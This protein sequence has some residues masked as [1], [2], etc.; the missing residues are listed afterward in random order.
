M[1]RQPVS[2][3]IRLSVRPLTAAVAALLGVQY[4]GLAM[5]QEG[6]G[7]PRQ[8]PL[9]EL[10]V[11]ASRRETTIQEIPFNIAAVS[12]VE[13]ERQ[14]IT[15]LREFA[16]TVP[17]LSVA[18]QGPRAAEL[19]TVR[20]LNVASL[21]ASEFL[22]N[23]GGET[24]A[25]YL[26]QVPLYI[27]FKMKDLERIEVLLGPQGTLYGEGTLAGAVR[28]MPVRPDT[29]RFSFDVHG[30]FYGLD[31]SSGTGLDTDAVW[32]V[33]LSDTLAFRAAVSYLDDPGFID[34][35]YVL[36]E[37]GVSN[38]QPDFSDPADVAANLIRVEDA[39]TEQTL[40]S[41]LALLWEISDTVEA[42]LNYYY[43]DQDVGGRTVNHRASFGTDIY[44]SGARF[45]EPNVR[46]NQLV[47]LEVVADLGFAELTSA[48]GVSSFEERG[49]R[50]QTDLLLDFEYGYEDFP[51][52]AAFT[53][54]LVDED[55]VNQEFRLVSTGEGPW[56]WIGGL[57]YN[58]YE[59]SSSSE[60]F[61][62]GFPEFID[63]I[64]PDNLE[65]RQVDVETLTET[66]LFGEVS[67]QF[68]ERLQLT[69]GA[70][71]FQ[72]D[73]DNATAVEIPLIAFEQAR[74][75]SGGDDG[76]LGKLNASYRFNE[77]MM[78]YVTLSEGYRSGGVNALP[79]CEIPLPPGQN[80]CALPQEKL[81]DPDTTLN[82]ELGLHSVWN[83]GRL[84]LNGAL[85]QID[86]TDIQT[87]TFSEN[88]SIPITINGS[89]ARSRGLEL[90]V[91]AP[92]VGPLS[93]AGSYA[94][95]H[96]EMTE[97][98]PGLVDGADAEAGDRLPGTP[99]HQGS[100]SA[101]YFRTLRNGY[102]LTVDYGMSFTSDVLTKIGQ[103]NDGETLGGFT[104]HNASIGLHRDQWSA[105]LFADNLTN[106]F[107]E[108]AVRLDPSFIRSVGG[109]DLRRYYRHVI[110]PRSIG[111][112]LRY[113]FGE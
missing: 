69:V 1:I 21:N 47:S 93:L 35:P 62:P 66:A 110:R 99:E 41:R 95:T 112:E 103:R 76:V 83:D 29:Q 57:F 51:S 26:G 2:K 31:Q 27:D 55:R 43:Q 15:S 64:Q 61:V 80:V 86:W 90:S 25:T 63:V 79:D 14:R 52:F 36:R 56:S 106:K 37:P 59:V 34:Y 104:V 40:S 32:N 68:T 58:D 105:V 74:S 100:F 96:A 38:P 18:D 73:N 94:Y 4:A 65:Y 67:Y 39:D 11:T 102:D 84:V 71:W 92:R 60:E 87:T 113:R 30:S 53:R 88:G 49:Q 22:A 17:G 28:Y 109:F 46:T 7:G 77:D 13:L 70:R 89:Q 101:S 19:M 107:A 111:V 42:T 98:A 3:P 108:T 5:A 85:F 12:G 50:D 48:T 91:Q 24:V 81:Y 10:I 16:R 33:P 54:E 8:L 20:G 78:G 44:A 23:A 9:E 82:Y 45:L 6:A 72:Y 97:F 75:N